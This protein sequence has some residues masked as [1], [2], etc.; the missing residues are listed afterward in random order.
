MAN[1]EIDKDFYTEN[2]EMEE[3]QTWDMFDF[4]DDR[5]DEILSKK[6]T[7]GIYPY[8]NVAGEVDCYRLL[9]TLNEIGIAFLTIEEFLEKGKFYCIDHLI[10]R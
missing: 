10:N 5:I 6:L 7:D 9:L 4:E 8:K 3:V 2:M 1:I